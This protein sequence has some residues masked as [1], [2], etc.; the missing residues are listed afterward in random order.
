MKKSLREFEGTMTVTI[1]IGQASKSF[2]DFSTNV[3][4]VY[5]DPRGTVPSQG[6]VP[7]AL[8]QPP[9]YRRYS[10]NRTTRG[11]IHVICS[12]ERSSAIYLHTTHPYQDSKAVRRLL[13]NTVLFT[14]CRPEPL[15]PLLFPELVFFT[16]TSVLFV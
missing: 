16:V 11:N 12:I 7:S 9:R 1:K 8:L 6:T 15:R 13:Q 2:L 5:E 14:V 3:V 4:D 10:S